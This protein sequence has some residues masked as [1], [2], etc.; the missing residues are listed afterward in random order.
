MKKLLFFT[1]A[2]LAAHCLISAFLITSALAQTS[3][4]RCPPL[5]RSKIFNDCF[6]TIRT[7]GGDIYS[8]EWRRNKKNGYGTYKWKDGDRYQ[9]QWRDDLHHGFGEFI[10]ANGVRYKGFFSNDEFEGYGEY[11]FA[12]GIKLVGEY[13]KGNR[14]G[15][16]VQFDQLGKIDSVGFYQSDKFIRHQDEAVGIELIKKWKEAKLGYDALLASLVEQNSISNTN[17]FVLGFDMKKIGIQN[18]NS[19]YITRS[20]GTMTGERDVCSMLEHPVFSRPLADYELAPKYNGFISLDSSRLNRYSAWIKARFEQLNIDT[21]GNVFIDLATHE[22]LNNLFSR[23]IASSNFPKINQSVGVF[24]QVFLRQQPDLSCVVGHRCIGFTSII[25]DN[26]DP[27][28]IVAALFIKE[29]NSELFLFLN[30][31]NAVIEK[32]VREKE[33]VVRQRRIQEE[34]SAKIQEII[35]RGDLTTSQKNQLIQKFQEN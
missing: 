30:E 3:L 19:G 29:A 14:E 15:T 35:G 6:G 34:R 33:E 31:L 18:R 20:V 7:T 13:K 10:F 11:L 9:G 27:S 16:H 25:V 26:F 2:S 5:D 17:F 21:M 1:V 28:N 8:G 4:P 24:L 32:R 23:C 12:D 22:N